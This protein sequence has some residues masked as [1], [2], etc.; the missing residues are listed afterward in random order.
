MS[1]MTPPFATAIFV[2]KGTAAPELGVTM[3]DIIRGIIPFVALIIVGILA[4]I[5]FPQIIL[6]LPG[7]MLVGW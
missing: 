7:K 5:A 6:W 2:C 4:C 1:F 3:A